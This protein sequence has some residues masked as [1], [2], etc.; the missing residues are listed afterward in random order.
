MRKYVKRTQVLFTEQ[1]YR[2]LLEIARQRHKPIG[3][4]IRE[5]AEKLYLKDERSR[6][7]TEALKSLL[8]LEETE[9]PEDY[10]QWEQQYLDEKSA[11]H[12]D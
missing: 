10:Q 11:Q 4:L 2:Q 6:Q 8:A 1:Q 7:K 9:V 5:A 12:E 3:V